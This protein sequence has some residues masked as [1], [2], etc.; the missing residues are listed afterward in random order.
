[1][2]FTMNPSSPIQINTYFFRSRKQEVEAI[3]EVI[4][5][6]VAAILNTVMDAITNIEIQKR[7]KHHLIS[8]M[9]NCSHALIEVGYSQDY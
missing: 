9:L 2:V 3:E 6:K 5:E 8:D 7:Y 4:N 1:M